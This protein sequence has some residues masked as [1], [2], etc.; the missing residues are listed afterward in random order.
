MDIKELTAYLRHLNAS[1]E[2]VLHNSES[3]LFELEDALYDLAE[4]L[5]EIRLG[6]VIDKLSEAAS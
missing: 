5:E 4:H 1:P 6:V 2:K 3:D